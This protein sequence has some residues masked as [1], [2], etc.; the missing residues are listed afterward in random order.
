[1]VA[2]SHSRA[3]CSGHTTCTARGM[4]QPTITDSH[5]IDPFTPD[6]RLLV[7]WFVQYNPMFTASALC[8]LGGVLL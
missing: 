2:T 7:R 1:M 8:V 6:P 4:S 3:V 5:I